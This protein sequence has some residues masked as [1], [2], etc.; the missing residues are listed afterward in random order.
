MKV[1]NGILKWLALLAIC[2]AAGLLTIIYL[3]ST[4][5]QLDAFW[6]RI[7]ILLAVAFI[8][9]LAFR[10]FFHKLPGFLL[11]LITLFTEML[12]LLVIDYFYAGTYRFSFLTSS[13]AFVLP[14]PSDAAQVLLLLLVMLPTLFFLRRRKKPAKI[15]AEPLPVPAA[16][17]AARAQVSLS[18]KAQ[19]IL[20]SINPANWQVTQD[21]GKQVKKIAKNTKKAVH[22][23][24]VH[25][26]SSRSVAKSAKAAAIVKTAAKKTASAKPAAV[27]KPKSSQANDVKLMGEEEHVCPYCLEKVN[28]NDKKVICPECGTWHHQDCWDLTG[29]C[30]VAHRN[31]L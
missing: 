6:L 9:S 24:P 27:R 7:A 2:L 8:G 5:P 4:Q 14:S 26:S 16:V 19:P 17:H 10:L 30:G 28:K 3:S 29:A 15:Q 1:V 25:V 20:N 18:Q 23:K 12:A 11:F 22:S 21:V 13:F 31:E